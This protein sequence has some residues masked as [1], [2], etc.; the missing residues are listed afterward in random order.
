MA[1]IAD[2]RESEARIA[3]SGAEV[4]EGVISDA[5]HA[6]ADAL[7]RYRGHD[8]PDDHEGRVSEALIAIW[9]EAGRQSGRLLIDEFKDLYALEAKQNE[10]SLFDQ[11]IRE[12]IELF[13]ARR[14]RQ[15]AAATREQIAQL[16]SDGQ[17]N[18]KGLPE[19]SKAIRQ[20]IPSIARMRSVVI[21]RTETHSSG[22]YASQ[23]VARSASKPLLKTWV[24]VQDHRTRDFGEGDGIVDEFS[25]RAMNGVTVALDQPYMVPTRRGGQEAM[26]FPGDPSA[27]A[28][29]VINCRCQEVYERAK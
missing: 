2:R 27:S 25:H 1:D 6:A 23:R 24:S 16:V 14:V 8:I 10:E 20:A 17:R 9:G 12:F 21:A 5:M 11:I 22:A 3:D 18:G 15:I 4:I 29:N 28:G 7:E 19:I 13:G 26:M